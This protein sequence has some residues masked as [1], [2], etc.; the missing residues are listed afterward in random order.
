MRLISSW[1]HMMSATVT[2]APLDSVDDYGKPTYGDA[3][4][5]TAHIARKN[6][7]TR[8]ATGETIVSHQTV[9][10]DSNDAILPTAQLTLSTGDIGSTEDVAL[11][12]RI[13]GV[14][15]RFDQN[16]P[17]HTVLFL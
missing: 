3:V 11:H 4:T 16:G 6:T 1:R 8:S 12:P 17:H 9:Y 10:L 5:Y 15:R 2:V 13:V 14:E 7:I